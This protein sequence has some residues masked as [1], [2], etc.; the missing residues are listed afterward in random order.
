M[1]D[2]LNSISKYPQTHEDFSDVRFFLELR[3]LMELCG[4]Y[5][6]GWKDLHSPTAKRFRSQVSA[7][8]NLAKFREDQLKLYAELNEPRIELL[9]ALDEANEENSELGEQLTVAQTDSDNKAK[10]IEQIEKEC[11]E[12]ELEIARKNKEQSTKREE[13]TEL[14]KK[15]N[16]LKDELETVKLALEEAQVECK[17]LQTKVVSSPER[18]KKN[19]TSLHETV[20]KEREEANAL[21]EKWQKTKTMIVHISQAIKDVPETTR[22]VYEVLESKLKISQTQD[23]IQEG[24]RKKEAIC[25]QC[26]EV[27]D[28][29]HASEATLNRSEEKL[30]HMR[31]QYRLKMDAALEAFES[32]KLEL[33]KIEKEHLEGMS[34]VEAGDNEVKNMEKL[35]SDA[36]KEAETGINSMIQNYRKMESNVLDQNAKFIAVIGE[37]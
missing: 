16:E 29:V 23:E 14:K 32:S 3:K 28:E 22:S 36:R 5:D 26:N 11:E 1:Q 24:K 20:K 6:F 9:C 15:H 21:E 34:K 25:K 18:R 33:M 2:T 31:K 19:V 17:S 35:I 10:E 13:A 8:I 37:C 7:A 12:L 30:S 4:Y 27:L